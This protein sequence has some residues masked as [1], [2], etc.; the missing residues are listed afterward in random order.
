MY[1]PVGMGDFPNMEDVA[2]ELTEP[3][4]KLIDEVFEL[5]GMM[6]VFRQSLMTFLKSRYQMTLRSVNRIRVKY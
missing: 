2:D 5:R 4:F 3:L 1:L 6:K